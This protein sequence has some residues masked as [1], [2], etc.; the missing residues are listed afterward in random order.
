MKKNLLF[1]ALFYLASIFNS[2]S[3]DQAGG[4]PFSFSNEGYNIGVEMV[5]VNPPDM[6]AIISEDADRA[7]KGAPYRIGISIP[8][9]YNAH[10]YGTWTSIPEQNASLWQLTIKCENAK[11]IGFGYNQFYLPQG[12]RLY[13]YNQSKDMVVGAYTEFNNADNQYFSNQKI[14][15]DQVTLELYIPDNKI[16]EL[17]LNISE[18]DYFYRGSQED[19]EKLGSGSC[20][21]NV[22]CSEG[23]SW[24]TQKKGVCKIDIRIGTFWYNCS[25]SL[26]NNTNQNCTPYVL[27]ADH[28]H[29]DG[30]YASTSD[31][32]AWK[33][34]FHYEASS[35]SGTTGPTSSVKTG[36]TLKAH[37]TYGQTGNGS[38]FCLVQINTAIATSFN[39]YYNG[40]NRTNSTST[41][42][43][44]IHH[45]AGDIKKIST[46]T[47]SLTS[48]N[49]GGTGTH[50]QVKWVATANGHGVTEGGSS[51]SPIFNSAGKIMGTLTGGS[52]Y[53]TAPTDPD[54]YG[55]FYYHWDKNGSTAAKRLKDWLD[56]SSTNV[57]ELDGRASC[58]T[59]VNEYK[60][61]EQDIN[62]YP[63]PALDEIILE[64][65]L[66]E[67]SIENITIYNLMGAVVKNINKLSLE[68]GKA[69]INVSELP[70]GVYYLNAYSGKSRFKGEFL[71][72]K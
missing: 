25:G 59:G 48:I 61:S 50:W 20:E 41:S 21:V 45:P 8:V 7:A 38:D 31:Y 26:V 70:E 71:K 57:T 68:T 34:Y 15:G 63:S 49:V 58:T 39:I 10:H 56:P 1:I 16:N 37:D 28:C 40:W 33:F 12:A 19:Q 11:S 27:L 17:K 65:G 5:T 54:Y 24:Q 64:T 36:C 46:Y 22:N 29:Y 4:I 51:G 47:A 60:T 66:T 30:G 53:C 62:I 69:K 32:N 2:F 55:K 13:L 43:V 14:N 9:S 35:C 72:S 67:G 52:S 42:G 23:S 18:L 6:S 3:Q 44:S